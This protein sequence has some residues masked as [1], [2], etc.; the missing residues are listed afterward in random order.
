[1]SSKAEKLTKIKPKPNSTKPNLA[2]SIKTK[3][4]QC[5]ASNDA[6]PNPFSSL[7]NKTREKLVKTT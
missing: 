5:N 1:M 6:L 2:K 3:I 7:Q 4:S